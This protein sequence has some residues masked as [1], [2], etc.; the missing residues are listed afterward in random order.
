MWTPIDGAVIAARPSNWANPF[1]PPCSR[2]ESARE[3]E[4]WLCT[5]TELLAELAELRAKR[6]APYCP[7]AERC[8][9]DAPERPTDW[10]L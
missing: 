7:L 1:Y 9:A 6:L 3:C 10:E 2:A 5:Q 4:L 8:H